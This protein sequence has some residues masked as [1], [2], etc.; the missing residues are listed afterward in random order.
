MIEVLCKKLPLSSILR[1][2]MER[3]FL[4]ERLDKLFERHAQEQYTQH[5]LFSTMCELL[6]HV[7]LRVHP[8]VHAAYQAREKEMSVSASA[9]YDKLKGVEVD[10]SAALVRETAKELATIQDVLNVK[11]S[12]WLPG[13][14]IRILDGNCLE[15]SEKRLHAHRGQSGA[16]LPGKSLVV[17]DAERGLLMDVFPCEDAYTQERLLVYKVLPTVKKNELWL[18]DRNFCV[19]HVLESI[20]ASKAFFLFR[21]HSGL[22]LIEHSPW[23]EPV[24]TAEG[25]QIM[26]QEVLVNGRQYRRIRVT[27]TEPTRDGDL[28]IDLITNLPATIS[29]ATIAALYRRRWTL[30]TA[31]QKLEAHLESEI[32]TLAYP[33]AALLGF[34][35]ALIVYNI[36][37]VTLTAIDSVHDQKP[38]SQDL[39]TYY[40]AHEIAST[41][42]AVL[43][44]S[45]DQEWHFLTTLPVNEFTKW[46]HTVAC[47][48]NIKKYKKHPRG[49]KKPPPKK[50]YDP[51]QPH[52]STKRLL[53]KKK[54][55]T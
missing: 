37:E 50:S 17:M 30:E 46:L 27:L 6:L 42:L 22:P 39:S 31:F 54:N 51:K 10:V 23:S 25:Q 24:M 14:K 55:N 8:S 13:Y 12:V 4:A 43:I 34:C 19:V 20:D 40:I 18:A 9:L 35:L 16:A 32:N 48:I 47:H 28:I 49:P 15:G 52:C 38:V 11:Q 5:L 2:L 21:L 3:C 44:L 45:D 29:A 26:E 36:F 33:R 41:F 1:G 53:P 7:V